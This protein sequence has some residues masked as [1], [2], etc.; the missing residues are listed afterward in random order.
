[1]HDVCIFT[2]ETSFYINRAPRYL[3]SAELCFNNVSQIKAATL[4]NLH[5]HTAW[6]STT[7]LKIPHFKNLTLQSEPRGWREGKQ[8]SLAEVE[9]M[10]L[11]GFEHSLTLK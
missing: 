8:Q 5:I 2:E 1:M 9:R 7:I 4:Q 10:G 6:A 3:K 11:R